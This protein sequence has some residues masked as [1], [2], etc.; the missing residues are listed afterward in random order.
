MLEIEPR[1]QVMP[2]PEPEKGI[3]AKL[4]RPDPQARAP[5]EYAHETP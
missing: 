5:A 4:E 3:Q 1:G 2:P